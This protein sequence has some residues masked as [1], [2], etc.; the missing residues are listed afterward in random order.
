MTG[1]G[2]VDVVPCYSYAISSGLFAGVSLEGVVLNELSAVNEK[3]YA[4]PG[5]QAKDILDGSAA[6]EQTAAVDK[7]HAALKDIEA[8]WAPKESP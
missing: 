5:V 2:L 3:F 7:L 4:K 1:E 6:V 8:L